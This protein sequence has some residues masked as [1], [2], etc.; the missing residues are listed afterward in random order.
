MQL[1]KVSLVHSTD[2][3][4]PGTVLVPVAKIET[5]SHAGCLL[6]EEEC[7]GLESVDMPPPLSPAAVLLV[8]CSEGNFT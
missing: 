5:R 7:T 8:M 2:I 6:A 1:P 4:L 3:Y